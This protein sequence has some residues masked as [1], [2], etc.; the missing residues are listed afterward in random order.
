MTIAE[1]VIV[2]GL[3]AGL[4]WLLGPL[5]RRIRQAIERRFYP[6]RARVIDAKF[7]VVDPKFR[8]PEDKH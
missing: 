4:L 6:N 1:F 3:V 2:A 8:D 5:R 7:R